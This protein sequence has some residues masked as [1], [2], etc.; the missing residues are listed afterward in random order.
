M[1]YRM[2]KQSVLGLCP[3]IIF[4]VCICCIFLY[5]IVFN[6]MILQKNDKCTVEVVDAISVDESLT[7]NNHN[8]YAFTKN[9]E[10]IKVDLDTYRC[11]VE[12]ETYKGKYPKLT[13]LEVFRL[14]EK[15]YWQE[16]VSKNISFY[17][18]LLMVFS[19]LFIPIIIIKLSQQKRMRKHQEEQDLLYEKQIEMFK[20]QFQQSLENDFHN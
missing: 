2:K 19:F 8:Y 5:Q 16:M 14:N 17:T 3:V 9:Q 4:Y 12:Y 15:L 6:M 13:H 7:R 11:I 20:K 1:Y 10:K 18:L